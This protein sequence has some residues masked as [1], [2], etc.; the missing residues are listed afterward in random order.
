MVTRHL[1]YNMLNNGLALGKPVTTFEMVIDILR[2]A[3]STLLKFKEAVLSNEILFVI[4]KIESNSLYSYNI[5]PNNNMSEHDEDLKSIYESL[6]EFSVNKKTYD[7]MDHFGAPKKMNDNKLDNNMKN[8]RTNRSKVRFKTVQEK[9]KLELEVHQEI[10][11]N[12]D[13]IDKSKDIIINFN[14]KNSRNGTIED[15]S[16]N[17]TNM[18]L[19]K[20]PPLENE[21][22]SSSVFNLYRK[23]SMIV[24]SM[25]KNVEFDIHSFYLEYTDRSYCTLSNAIFEELGLYEVFQQN[26]E[27]F[28]N[29]SNCIRRG[30]NQVPYHNEKHGIDVAHTLFTYI[31]YAEEF[32]AKLKISKLDMMT[33]L[34]AGLCHDIGHPGY[35]NSFHINSLSSF[36]VSYNDKSVL[37]NFH[38]AE[39]TRILMEPDLNFLDC[40]EGS[41]FKRFRKQFIEAILATDMTFHAKVNSLV[42]NRL[43][44]NSI[45]GGVNIDKLVPSNDEMLEAHLDLFNFLLHLADLSHNAKKFD[46]SLIWV[47]ALCEEFWSQGDTE[48]AMN[49]PISFNCDRATADVP[50]GQIGFLGFIILPSYEILIDIFP[51]LVFLKQNLEE[52]IRKWKEISEKAVTKENSDNCQIISK[53]KNSVEVESKSTTKLIFQVHF[54]SINLDDESIMD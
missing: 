4:S 34:V 53:A 20:I 30:Y 13:S 11:S 23:D 45:K 54:T 49:L 50:K 39:A 22:A 8:V 21:V 47:N 10:S 5:E 25:I 44:T 38:S 32:E 18:L 36:A 9:K 19:T 35:N 40:L 31:Y 6:C 16:N 41:Q 1:G 7:T 17:E 2:R 51:N 14:G 33:L 46:V 42:K 15:N 26:I 27:K 3:S 48:R 29:F 12:Y 24:R 43:I 52:N 37:E 28:L